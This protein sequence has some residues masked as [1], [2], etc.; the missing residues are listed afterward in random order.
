MALRKYFR[1]TTSSRTESVML[2]R[3]NL[4]KTPVRM[5]MHLAQVK[6]YVL[7]LTGS[8]IRNWRNL[9]IGCS[10]M[11]ILTGLFVMYAKNGHT[12]LPRCGVW[13]DKPFT[14]WRKAIEKMR[15]HD[16]SK[17]HLECCQIALKAS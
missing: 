3:V 16:S 7:N 4:L 2:L 17:L 1:S 13:I 9:F 12:Q 8:T 15:S 6:G 11:K 10:M 14:N 5:I